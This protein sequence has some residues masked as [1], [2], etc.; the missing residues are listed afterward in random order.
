MGSK[1]IF[2]PFFSRCFFAMAATAI[3]EVGK[4]SCQ[5]DTFPFFFETFFITINTQSTHR[6][7]FF[8]YLERIYAINWSEKIILFPFAFQ[9][10]KCFFQTQNKIEKSWNKYNFWRFKDNIWWI[11]AAWKRMYVYELMKTFVLCYPIDCL[12]PFQ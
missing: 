8:L 12:D 7:I 11:F 1:V 3:N 6:E 9:G 5:D 4:F 10:G 2:A